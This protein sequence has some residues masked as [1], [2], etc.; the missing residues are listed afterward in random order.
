MHLLI[1][2]ALSE[3]RPPGIAVSER[4]AEAA[5]EVA[6]HRDGHPEGA[7]REVTAYPYELIAPHAV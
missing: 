1:A 3:P 7:Y 2:G 6:F 4:S 5:I